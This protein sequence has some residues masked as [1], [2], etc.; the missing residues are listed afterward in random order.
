MKWEDKVTARIKRKLGIDEKDTSQ[1]TLIQDYI[2]DTA[3]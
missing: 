1:D 3:L 2:Y